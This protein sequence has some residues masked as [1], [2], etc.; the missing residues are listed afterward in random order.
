MGVYL[1]GGVKNQWFPLT[2]LVTINT[3]QQVMSSL[4]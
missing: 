4:L 1:W 3:V 2:K